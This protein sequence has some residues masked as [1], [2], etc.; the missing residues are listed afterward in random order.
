MRRYA[1]YGFMIV[2]LLALMVLGLAPFNWE[3]N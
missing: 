3:G 2:G 1:G